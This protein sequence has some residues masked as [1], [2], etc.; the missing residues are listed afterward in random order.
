MHPKASLSPQVT[1]ITSWLHDVNGDAIPDIVGKTDGGLYVWYGKGH[2][3]FEE[4]GDFQRLTTKNDR[5]M[6]RL[7]RYDLL[8]FDLNRDGLADILLTGP[9]TNYAFINQNGRFQELRLPVVVAQGTA[10][11]YS[12]IGDLRGSGNTAI[13]FLELE[14][15]K[16]FAIEVHGPQTGLLQEIDDG[17]G[18]RIRFYYMRAKPS[19][20]LGPRQPLLE[21]LVISTSGYDDLTV[22]YRY[23][24]P[25]LHSETKYLVGYARVQ[26][27]APYL[28]KIVEYIHDDE[29]AAIPYHEELLDQGMLGILQL[30][31]HDYEERTF[32]GIRWRRLLESKREVRDEALGKTLPLSLT[33]FTSYDREVC[34]K[35]VLVENAWGQLTTT[36]AVAEV[37]ELGEALHCLPSEKRLEG[38]HP[39]ADFDFAMQMTILRNEKGQ[40]THLLQEGAQGV[41]QQQAM[42]YHPDHQLASLTTAAQGTTRFEYD[43]ATSLLRQI[44]HPDGVIDY[45]TAFDSRYHPLGLVNDRGHAHSLATHLRYDGFE[46]YAKRWDDFS[47]SQETVPSEVVEYVFATLSSAGVITSKALVDSLSQSYAQQAEVLTAEGEPYAKLQ[48]IP[49]GWAVSSLVQ[50]QRS[51][52]TTQHL[53]HPPLPASIE[54]GALSFAHFNA[55]R[56]VSTERASG[57]GLPLSQRRTVQQQIEQLLD[58]RYS[59][60]LDEKNQGLFLA[61]TTENNNA[62]WQRTT[63][64]DAEGHVVW[65]RDALGHTTRFHYDALGRLVE[66]VLPNGLKHQRLFDD[67]GRVKSVRR[68]ELGRWEY[69]Y[70][71]KTGRLE[72][73][74]LY[75]RDG[76]KERELRYEYDA[77]GRITTQI[78]QKEGEEAKATFF[79]YDGQGSTGA[80]AAGQRGY[81]TG[82]EGERYQ[83]HF[84]YHPDGTLKTTTV[85]F[86]GW[87]TVETELSYYAGKQVRTRRRIVKDAAG[88]LIE[89]VRFDYEY[90]AYGRLEGQSL[91]VHHLVAGEEV[92][93]ICPL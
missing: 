64:R 88:H 52:L 91:T 43:L 29:M 72:T 83:K 45:V 46:R 79:T 77:I 35:S 78:Q 38:R 67:Y 4:Q 33:R 37:A 87:L 92:W 57:Q 42:G 80:G 7:G 84:V 63:A 17:K 89:E 66:A 50:H 3:Q 16:V 31:R 18:S 53:V 36:E 76:K 48:R 70:E 23:D 93:G 75:D 8:F 26:L 68:D 71:P 65:Q 9:Y 82:V 41:L 81:L 40:I 15:N 12:V 13:N 56:V 24:K 73:K 5:L 69:H 58:T 49:E 90:D 19:K 51:T 54:L 21:R 30:T 85:A 39:R 62:A 11:R 20:N 32:N 1:L 22:S 59:I 47:G 60:E 74:S 61:T 28:T 86:D 6:G 14:K 2:F 25:V 10:I 27:D 34:P 44:I 55:P